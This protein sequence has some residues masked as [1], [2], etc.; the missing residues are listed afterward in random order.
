MIVP[1]TRWREP[2]IARLTQSE[3]IILL[4]HH[5]LRIVAGNE[6]TVSGGLG[7]LVTTHNDSDAT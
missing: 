1:E 6:P 3:A 7:S 5:P 4:G 2:N